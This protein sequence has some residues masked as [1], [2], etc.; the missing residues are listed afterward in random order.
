MFRCPDIL[1]FKKLNKKEAF[2]LSR[3]NFGE[4]DYQKELNK[5]LEEE[6]EEFLDKGHG[7]IWGYYNQ[8]GALVG[9]GAI[10][11]GHWK[12]EGGHKKEIVLLYAIAMKL[13]FQ[14]K[15]KIEEKSCKYSNQIMNHLISDAKLRNGENNIVGLL[16]HPDNGAAM[17]LYKR[18]EFQELDRGYIDPNTGQAYCRFLRCLG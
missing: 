8:D 14:G 15:P 6:S 5:F 2:E 16:V 3:A 9:F 17:S 13:E 4:A 7:D 1:V 12:I 11:L 18:F 10:C